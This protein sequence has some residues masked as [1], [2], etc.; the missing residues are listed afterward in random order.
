MKVEIRGLGTPEPVPSTNFAL[1]APGMSGTVESIGT[2]EATTRAATRDYIERAADGHV[3]AGAPV[4]VV[5]QLAL[6]LRLQ[7]RGVAGETRGETV[8]LPT[9][10]VDMRDESTGYAVLYVDEATGASRWLLDG[11]RDDT[12]TQKRLAFELPQ[13]VESGAAKS[14]KPGTRG[15][16]T[17]AMRALVKVVA[18][19]TDP[20]VGAAAYAVAKAWENKRRPYGLQQVNAKGELIDPDWSIFTGEPT[21]LLVHG[22]FSTPA[23]GFYGWLGGQ[24]FA[25]VHARY[26]GRCLAFAHPT[27]HASPDENIAWLFDALPAGKSWAFDTVSHSRGGL[28]V[29]ALAA[30][31]TAKNNCKVARMVMVAPPNFGTPLADAKHW[32]AFLNAHTNLLVTSPD[33][34]STIVAEGVLCLVKILGRGVADNLPGLSAMNLAAEYLPALARRP[35]GSVDGMFVVASDYA[36]ANRDALKQL[37]LSAADSAVDR[38]FDEANDLVVPTLGCSEGPLASA[39]FPIPVERL[40]RLSGSTHHCNF[41]EN[42]AVQ[43]KLTTWLS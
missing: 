20:L 36:P 22:T 6:D 23:A 39:G 40:D 24:E 3:E 31:A 34:V 13:V 27:M 42:A 8:G 28:V 43:Q 11:R 25:A 19:V 16:I 41:F 7:L 32:T 15:M 14:E 26:G 29:R 18:W 5:G 2:R 38:F 17:G 21:L 35:I 10:H 9:L 1:T 37:L 4:A 33:T 12:A 30:H